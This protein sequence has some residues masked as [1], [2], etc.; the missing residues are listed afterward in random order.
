MA[1]SFGGE[2]LLWPGSRCPAKPQAQAQ[3]LL[4]GQLTTS[5]CGVLKAMF[6]SSWEFWAIPIILNSLVRPGFGGKDGYNPANED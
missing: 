4:L 5:F 2:G 3:Q 6:W 1:L